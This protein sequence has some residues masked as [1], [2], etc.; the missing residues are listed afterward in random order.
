MQTTSKNV[1]TTGSP[2]HG[3]GKAKSCSMVR[4]SSRITPAWAG[5][6]PGMNVTS[7]RSGDHPR[8]GG[9]KRSSLATAVK[10]EG[11]PPHGRGKAGFSLYSTIGNRITPAWAGKSIS[12]LCSYWSSWDHPRMGGEK[13]DQ[14]GNRPQ[15]AG[16]P[17][18]GRGKDADT[19]Y[20]PEVEGITPAWA[21]KRPNQRRPERLVRDHPRMGGEKTEHCSCMGIKQ[22]SPPHGRGKV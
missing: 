22:G 12:V 13:P 6:R 15:R 9:E 1:T 18:H 7:S 10:I 8:M 3:R 11:S 20:P 21:G 14:R 4:I 5:K 19:D 2:P 16:S 17:P